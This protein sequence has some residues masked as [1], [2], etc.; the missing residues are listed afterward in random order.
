M[1]RGI[2]G[3]QKRTMLS[4]ME[5]Q[6]QIVSLFRA[7]PNMM[8]IAGK[9]VRQSIAQVAPYKQPEAG[10]G[11]EDLKKNTVADAI[12]QGKNGPTALKNMQ[13]L[14][15]QSLK[16]AAIGSTPINP[17]NAAQELLN[18]TPEEFS[19]LSKRA[20]GAALKVPISKEE[21][22]ANFAKDASPDMGAAKAQELISNLTKGDKDRAKVMKG[23]IDQLSG[24]T[25]QDV[26]RVRVELDKF[27][28]IK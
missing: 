4:I 1:L 23:L 28:G 13:A 9:G 10:V 15:A 8:T 27:L 20:G 6:I 25:K 3:Q 11:V 24:L 22:V 19:E 7:M 16:P 14:I 26:D 18:L 2:A 5:A 21:L 17:K 12:M